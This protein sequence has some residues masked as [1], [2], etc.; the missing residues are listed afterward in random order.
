MPFSIVGVR[1][2]ALIFCLFLSVYC[3]TETVKSTDNIILLPERGLCAHRGA[4]ATH[5]ENTVPAFLA[6]IDAGAHMIEFDVAITKDKE[7]VVIHDASVDRTTNGTGRVADLTLAQIRRLDAGSWKSPGFKGVKIPTFDEVLEIMPV[8]IWLNIHLKGEDI[9]G[10][11]VS[12]K[13]RDKKR[14]HQA[15][16][17]CGK[18][19]AEKAREVVPG[20]MICNMDRQAA[21]I[22]YVKATIEMGAGFIQLRRDIYPGFR[23]YTGLLKDNG[24]RVNYYGTDDPEKIRLLFEYGVDFPLVDDIV[25]TIKE[26]S[27]IGIDPVMPAALK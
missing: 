7:L 4:M 17:A 25:N 23:E 3:C 24:I 21:N 14:L 20:I 15:F 19:A 6:A 2:T 13:L 10:A 22:D 27:V 16:L 26:V 18:G 12:E 11:M 8:N 1:V 9:A 5:P